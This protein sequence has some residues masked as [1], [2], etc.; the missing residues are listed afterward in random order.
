MLDGTHYFECSCGSDEHTLRFT[1][2]KEDG[3]LYTSVFLNDWL[4]WYKRLWRAFR[5]V[6]GYKCKFGHWDCWIMR[7]E[8]VDKLR[9]LID[10]FTYSVNRDDR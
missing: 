1:L 9:A 6:F 3:E 10:E 7:R 4:P 2:N 8:D 5:Y